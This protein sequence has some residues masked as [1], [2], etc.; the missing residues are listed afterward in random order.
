MS[1]IPGLPVDTE[2]PERVG[3]L[4]LGAGLAG[5]AAL[6]A[7]AEAGQYA[8][9]LE[10]TD[11]IGGSTVK[12]AGLSAF[13]G[14]DEQA[15]QGIAD[16][17]ELL[18]KDLLEVGKERNDPALVE[19][20][21]AHQ[22]E[23]YRWLKAHGV[24]YGE[25]HAASGQSAPRSH[26][27]DTTRM[28][29]Q[30]L[31]AAGELGAR[32][33]FDAPAERLLHDGARVTGVRLADGRE[34]LADAVVLGTGGFSMN[35]DLLATFAP[36]MA[37]AL[38][39]GGTGNQGDGLKM[40]MALGAG[41][42]DTPYIKGTYGH[43]HTEHPDEDG[44][45]ILAVYKGA[46]AV[47]REGRRFVDESRNYKEIGD[48]ALV[49]PGV[50]T[51]QVFDARTMALS[52]DEV[53]IYEFAGRERAGMLL[54]A[55]TIAGLEAAIGLPEGSLQ[56]T[57]AEYNAALA[58]GGDDPHGRAHLSGGVGRPTPID[59]GPFYAHPSGT[60][61]LATYCGLTVDTR[62]RVLDWWGEPIE[63]LYA[64]GEI[65]GGFHGAGYMTG[66]SIGKSGVFGRIAGIHAA[67]EESDLEW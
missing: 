57:V 67:A 56:E 43:F 16:S 10:K 14:T 37:H 2:L 42:R 27:T 26:P 33:V 34:V 45:G 54:K 20:Y 12:S 35:P 5:C 18:R 11:E 49:Q 31:R 51:W 19:L 61:V 50:T 59:Q 21:C 44:T 15:E 4:V 58:G 32:I 6:L 22:L 23:T 55:D 62:M 17:V 7:A 66:T 29:V 64:A 13:A 63:R 41:L 40:A 25:I 38:R 53:P 47:N 52:N 48:A 1:E 36:Q 46:I 24:V 28:L 39:Q 3:V 30:L 65:T 60:V 8:L 9:L